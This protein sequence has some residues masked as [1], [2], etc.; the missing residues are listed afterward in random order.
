MTDITTII[1]EAP[2]YAELAEMAEALA[3]RVQELEAALAH[4]VAQFGDVAEY[5]T[6]GIRIAVEQARRAIAGEARP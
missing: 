4:V 5:P 2:T 6:Q 1:Q 3:N